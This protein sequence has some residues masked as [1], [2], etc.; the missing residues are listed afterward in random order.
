MSAAPIVA[1]GALTRRVLLLGTAAA[2]AA[3]VAGCGR[4]GP[5]RPPAA[6]DDSKKDGAS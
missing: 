4:K 5:V 2:V 6:D 3:T 1:A